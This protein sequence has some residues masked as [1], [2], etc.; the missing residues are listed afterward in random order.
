MK[1]VLIV[2]LALVATAAF[3][4]TPD[5]VYITDLRPQTQAGKLSPA[6]LQ[7]ARDEADLYAK[8]SGLQPLRE[9]RDDEVRFWLT[10]ATFD[11]STNAV[12]SGKRFNV[13]AGNPT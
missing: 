5:P 13:D 7:D 9:G 10:W 3:A 2:S 8:V 6:T 11:P 1:A 12:A 4:Q